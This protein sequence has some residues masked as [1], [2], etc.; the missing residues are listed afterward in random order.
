MA[1]FSET[2]GE[3][4]LLQSRQHHYAKKIVDCKVDGNGTRYYKVKWEPTWEPANELMV[5]ANLIDEYWNL[6]RRGASVDGW[7]WKDTYS[8]IQNNR[9][10]DKDSSNRRNIVDLQRDTLTELSSTNVANVSGN[11]EVSLPCTIQDILHQPENNSQSTTREAEYS[12]QSPSVSRSICKIKVEDSDENVSLCSSEPIDESVGGVS[13]L[14]FEVLPNVPIDALPSCPSSKEQMLQT[15]FQPEPNPTSDHEV[16]GRCDRES[17]S[18]DTDLVGHS[19]YIQ[20][21]KQSSCPIIPD[22]NNSNLTSFQN[23]QQSSCPTNQDHNESSLPS[24]DGNLHIC[25]ICRKCFTS[26]INLKRHLMIHSGVNPYV[27]KI[28]KKAFSQKRHLTQHMYMHSA[29]SERFK[30][31]HCN[32]LYKFRS[33]YNCHVTGCAT[34]KFQCNQCEKVLANKRYLLQHIAKVHPNS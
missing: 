22:H 2:E 21:N 8:N 12:I 28:C 14:K 6:I 10:I 20:N 26:N 13:I 23:H 29:P 30:C 17:T 11:H 3:C 33:S 27:C 16:E 34:N 19:T 18:D 1:N 5:N 15:N 25:R 31:P 32:K 7:S 24:S 4:S 9:S